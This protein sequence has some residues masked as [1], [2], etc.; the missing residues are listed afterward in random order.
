MSRIKKVLKVIGIIFGS[1]IALFIVV[2]IILNI[3]FSIQLKNTIAELKEQGRPMTIAEIVP[4]PVPDEENAAILYN[5]AFVLMTSGEGG[6][7]YIPNK[8]MGTKNNVIK[9][10]EEVKSYSDI[11]KWT[12]EQRKEIREQVNSR[13][14]QEIYALLEEGSRKPKCN[15]NLDYEKG[16]DMTLPHLSLMRESERLLCLRA[17]LEAEAGKNAQAFDTLLVGLKISNHLKD[18]PILITQLVRIECDRI[19]MECIKSISDLMGISVEKA[20]LIMNEL[21]FHQ[22]MEPFIKCM[23]GEGVLWGGWAFERILRGKPKGL[24]E[25]DFNNTPTPLLVIRAFLG[26]P[27]FKKDYVCYLTLMS[28]MQDSYNVDYYAYENLS[29]RNP[30]D[31]EIEQLPKYCVL[32]RMLIPS[33]D[34]TREH[35][36]RHQADIDVCRTGLALKI[37]KLKNVSYPAD[38]NE[39]VSAGLLSEVPIDPFS[40]KSLV[41]FRHIGGFKLYSFGPNMQDDFGAKRTH[42]KDSPAY[43]NYDIVWQSQIQLKRSE[44]IHGN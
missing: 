40:G 11:S 10:I 9:A 23:D 3:I 24:K 42:E 13:Q 22:G 29:K 18:E 25:I 39:L 8:E 7:P 19:I 1:L 44:Y 43:E 41:Y 21:S 5:K 35:A 31:L 38:L 36:A 14:L 6:I 12:D 30:I 27:I 32:T 28:R 15:F 20:N 34:K 37:F 26:K 16:I 33:L 17:L 2:H 4:A